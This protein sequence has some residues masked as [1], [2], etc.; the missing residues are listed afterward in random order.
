MSS[1][2][3]QM[4][5]ENR[6]FQPASRKT[7]KALGLTNKRTAQACDR[8]RAKKSR[9][10][11]KQ[12]ACSSCAAAGMECVVSDRL[13]RKSYPKGYTELLEEQSRQLIV[14][15]AR[16]KG[17]LTMRDEQ[18]AS[19]AA[20][21]KE[22]LP[23][24][25]PQFPATRENSTKAV[26]TSGDFLNPHLVLHTHTHGEGCACCLGSPA[27]HERPVSVAGSV[28]NGE[29]DAL[30]AQGSVYSDFDEE[31]DENFDLH[32]NISRA[33]SHFQGEDLD[34]SPGHRGR[35]GSTEYY[36]RQIRPAPGAFAAATAIEQ[37]ENN[38]N[39]GDHKVQTESKEQMLTSLV[40][41]SVPRSTEETLF[42]PTLLARVCEAYGYSSTPSKLTASAIAS[43]K[44]T[45][46]TNQILAGKNKGHP[47]LLSLIINSNLSR[48]ENPD[49]VRFLQQLSLP[50]KSEL[51]HLLK[52]YFEDWGSVMPII[53]KNA[54]LKNYLRFSEI[55]CN[56]YSEKLPEYCYELTEKLG[57]LVVL[58]VSL[59]LLLKKFMYMNTEGDGNPAEYSTTLAHFD[60][61]IHEF[62]KPNCI[63]TKVCSLQS[64]QILALALQY[65]LATGDY[66]T[67]YELRGRV[68]TMAQQLRLH[69]CPAA[70]LGL[71]REMNDRH[72]KAFMQGERRIVFW[73]VYVLDVYSS[74]NLGVPRLLKDYEIECATPFSGKSDDDDDEKNN[75]NILIVNNTKLTIFGK[76]TRTS[77]C[78]MQFCKVLGNIMDTI[79]SRSGNYDVREKALEKDQML[80]C[81]RR[82]LPADLRFDTDVNGFLFTHPAENGTVQ[83]TGI[84]PVVYE[85]QRHLL[86]FLYYHGKILIYLP[87]ISK[88]GYHHNVGL[89]MKEKLA[90]GQS[91]ISTNVS[92]MSIIQQAAVQILHLLKKFATS[93][94]YLLPVPIN[95]PREHA[96][97]AILVA[98]GSLDY[99]KGG[100][101]HQQLKQ[102][103]LDTMPILKT[104]TKLEIPSSLTKRSASLLEYAILS[105]LGLNLGRASGASSL[106]KRIITNESNSKFGSSRN[107]APY[108]K[109]DA[110][111]PLFETSEAYDVPMIGLGSRGTN[112]TASQSVAQGSPVPN[113]SAIPQLSN[114]Q[115]LESYQEYSLSIDSTNSSPDNNVFT[116]QTP[117]SGHSS[118]AFGN[119]AETAFNS[120]NMDD[121][122]E[123]FKFDDLIKNFGSDVMSSEFVTD[124][125]LGLVP[126]LNEPNEFFFEDG[127]QAET[128]FKRE[129][130]MTN[131]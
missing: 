44:D 46:S 19:Y 96:R 37:M 34:F 2:K 18:L 104:E 75:E 126:F 68:I 52:V 57:A 83:N 26:A 100:P 90:I 8:C 24:A 122:G 54:F 55:L 99:I 25:Q 47:E 30:S 82:D 4:R 84:D 5:W 77:L 1:K 81:W 110:H 85:K 120:D 71:S 45:L 119:Q 21:L 114:N 106:R 50:P 105:I 51:D 112:G 43:L 64:L 103:L 39:A 121:N 36:N 102:L 101:L 115:L 92:S 56:G 40:A 7:I 117:P 62:I 41:V 93:S 91:D 127:S 38:R 124:G 94:P 131:V 87:I 15:N 107:P 108:A 27:V 109:G 61:L 66:M 88:Y 63:L 80:D 12:P 59:A 11:G 31:F 53:N 60:V 23:M 111:E 86:I 35:N 89:S 76:V 22:G 17:V 116:F 67:C 98:K 70:V 123:F 125:S 65:C 32:S 10:D 79:F 78:L 28:Y 49:A 95:V 130:D 42:I 33:D 74:L 113:P 129:F 13:T 9:C 20:Q 14:E 118:Q 97:F 128:Q 58:V 72:L 48:L 69:R 3:I 29:N 16:L 73:C 6:G